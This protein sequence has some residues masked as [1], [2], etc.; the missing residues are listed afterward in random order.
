MKCMLFTGFLVI[1]QWNI[2]IAQDVELGIKAGMN[3]ATLGK[4]DLGY[5]S[6]I[7][8]HLGGSAEFIT[9]PFFSVQ[10]ELL[11]SLQ[12]A[13]TEGKTQDIAGHYL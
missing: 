4:S 3:V 1:V 9:T 7:A 12:G 5:V 13:A 10:T 11:Y 8:Y 6:R 2:L